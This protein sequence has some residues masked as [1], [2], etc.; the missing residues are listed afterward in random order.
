M[1]YDVG[2]ELDEKLAEGAA[3]KRREEEEAAEQARQ[4]MVALQQ[5]EEEEEARD[6]ELGGLHVRHSM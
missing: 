4:E 5:A 2:V 6:L 1:A 3:E